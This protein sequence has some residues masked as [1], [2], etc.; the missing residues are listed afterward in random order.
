MAVSAQ[1]TNEISSDMPV[2]ELRRKIN[3]SKKA[4][5]FMEILVVLVTYNALAFFTLR[6]L[7]LESGTIGHNWD[8]TISPLA[9]QLKVGFTPFYVWSEGALGGSHLSGLNFASLS[10]LWSNFGYLGLNGDFVSKFLLFVTIFVAGLTMFALVEDILGR[11][12]G[13]T[14]TISRAQV[15]FPSLLAGSFYALSPFL[16]CEFIGGSW[17][18]F[19]SYALLPLAIYLFRKL[20]SSGAVR[21]IV[22]LA[23]VLSMTAISFQNLFLISLILFLYTLVQESRL[24]LLRN[25]LIT[26]VVF[27]VFNFYW[28]CPLVYSIFRGEAGSVIANA[29][30]L[31]NIK[32]AVPSVLQVFIGTGYSRDFF[33]ASVVPAIKSLWVICSFG[34]IILTLASLF[35]LGRERR[36]EALFWAIMLLSSFVFATGG[37]GPL[38]NM[39]LWLYEHVQYMALFRSPQHFMVPPTIFLSML[40][41]MG[42]FCFLSHFRLNRIPIYRLNRLPIYLAIVAMMTVWL[43]PFFTGNLGLAYLEKGGGGNFVANFQVSPGFEKILAE[44]RNEGSDSRVLY[45]PVSSSPYY[46]ATEYQREGQGGD[47]VVGGTPGAISDGSSN[48]YAEE[49]IA[50]LQDALCGEDMPQNVSMLLGMANAKYMILRKDVR[51]NFGPFADTWSYEQVYENLKQAE[52]IELIEECDYVSLWENKNYLPHIYALSNALPVEGNIDEIIPVVSTGTFD[53]RD[54]VVFFS[55]QVSSSQW[56]FIREYSAGSSNHAP[57]ISFEK[58][59]ATKYQVKVTNATEPFFLV[60]SESYD[61]QWKAYV[62]SRGGD[63]NWMEA[64][65]RGAI[66]SG[67]H[68]TVNGYANAWYIDPGKLGTGAEFSVT[69]YFQPQSSFYLGWI[70][71]GLTFAGCIGLLVWCWR[72]GRR[73]KTRD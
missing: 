20:A 25:L 55:E 54:S 32:N 68:F 19:F 17:T 30:Y 29:V 34:L 1:R 24:R 14:G 36:K 12:F 43:S 69:L 31:P 58:V 60:F 64:F 2:I 21:H 10:F 45:L 40:L 7:L 18:Q 16:F 11:E 72:R 47:P 35:L 23:I 67:E 44:L 9:D 13:K 27:F 56:Q 22:L 39:V 37:K 48:P 57:E 66:S 71:S 46:L 15:F 50:M 59:N 6:K 26:Y 33:T 52:G 61:S 41:G 28:I 8:W 38:G 3:R 5:R 42:I 4:S 62:N 65:F 63:T 73:L 49:Y 53:P 51:P 70:I